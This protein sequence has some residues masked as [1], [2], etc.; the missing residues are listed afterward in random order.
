MLPVVCCWCGR[1]LNTGCQS[2][3]LYCWNARQC[4][5]CLLSS[6]VVVCNAAGGRTGRPA[7]GRVGGRP[8]PGRPRGQSSGRH[9]TAGQYGY[10]PLGRH[11]FN[12]VHHSLVVHRAF[13]YFRDIL[14]RQSVSMK[15]KK[16]NLNKT[17]HETVNRNILKQKINPK[18]T[19]RFCRFVYHSCSVR[20]KRFL[21]DVNSR[22]RSLYAIGRPSVVCLSVVCNVGAPYS[23][24]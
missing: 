5:W 19:A 9:C 23:A 4:C 21:A 13:L 20:S 2:V 15:L 10:V 7:G 16:L 6:S 24:G 12:S 1:G 8:P 14:P 17:R 22:S 3:G 11:F 18:T